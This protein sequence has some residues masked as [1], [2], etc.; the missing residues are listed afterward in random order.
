MGVVYLAEGLQDA[1]DAKEYLPGIKG[2]L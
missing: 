2:E 1:I